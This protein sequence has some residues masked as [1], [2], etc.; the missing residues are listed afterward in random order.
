MA[1]SDTDAAASTLTKSQA[2]RRERVIAAAR[3]LGSEGG[4]EVVQM[5]EVADRADVALGTIYR[6][7][8]SKDHLLAAVLVQWALDLEAQVTKRLPHDPTTSDRLVKILQRA[9]RAMEADP[10]LSRAVLTAMS[11][12]DPRVQECQREAAQ[13]MARIQ[14]LA[15]DDDFDPDACVGVIR[16]LGQVWFAALIG[17]VNGWSNIT[18]V[19]DELEFAARFLLDPYE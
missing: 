5:R 14:L 10:D 9:A 11:K 1:V 8:S 12:S 17:W 3:A 6:Y 13:V 2:A 7:F 16:L 4:Y 15:F 19:S 18:K